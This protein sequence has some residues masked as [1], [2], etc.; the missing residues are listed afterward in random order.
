MLVRSEGLEGDRRVA[1]TCWCELGS[2][3]AA[4]ACRC[5]DQL[6]C[7][8][9]TGRASYEVKVWKVAVGPSNTGCKSERQSFGNTTMCLPHEHVSVALRSSCLIQCCLLPCCLD[10]IQCR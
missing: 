10:Y 4:G 5:R 3:A 2:A 8:K 1:L 9:S 6:S 7:R